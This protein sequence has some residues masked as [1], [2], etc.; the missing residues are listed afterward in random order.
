MVG[1]VDG[2]AGDANFATISSSLL[3]LYLRMLSGEFPAAAQQRENNRVYNTPVVILL[4]IASC[5]VGSSS[6]LTSQHEGYCT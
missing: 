4:I 2:I 1:A 5:I 3:R 6:A